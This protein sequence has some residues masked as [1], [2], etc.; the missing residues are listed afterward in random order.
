MLTQSPATE[1][2]GMAL[3]PAIHGDVQ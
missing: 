1:R 2:P 3:Q